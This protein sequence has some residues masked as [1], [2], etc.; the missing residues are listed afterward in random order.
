MNKLLIS[1]YISRLTKENIYS[2]GI[3][4]GI[5]MQSNDLD[6]IYY[7]IK[8]KYQEFFNNPDIILKEIKPQITNQAYDIII[9][10][11]NKYKY[12]M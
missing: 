12:L 11:Y 6:I 4:Q 10:L 9:N 7:Y 8:N 5:T 2:F 3:K 1:E